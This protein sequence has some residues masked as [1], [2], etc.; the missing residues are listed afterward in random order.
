MFNMR[1]RD[2]ITLIGGA[3]AGW[4]LSAR[5]QQKLP[6]V[7]FLGTTDPAL[8][9]KEVTAFVRR[10]QELGWIEG[11]MATRVCWPSRGAA[12]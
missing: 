11:P 10:L 8:W 3:A 7:E 4:P 6:T 2:V 9:N 5:A 1:R 12:A